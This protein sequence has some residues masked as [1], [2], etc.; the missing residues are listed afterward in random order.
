[1]TKPARRRWWLRPPRNSLPF[2][3]CVDE[4]TIGGIKVTETLPGDVILSRE[5]AEK[6]L[7]AC[8]RFARI[9]ADDGDD[10]EGVH[11]DVILRVE[12][13]ARDLHA[14]RDVVNE[15]EEAMKESV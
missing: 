4:E 6:I 7:G 9:E 12:I 3:A 14:I 15:L 2:G 5:D 13:T 11:A 10:F 1:M 8:T